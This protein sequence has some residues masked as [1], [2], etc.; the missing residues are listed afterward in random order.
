MTT[1]IALVFAAAL[2]SGCLFD[3]TYCWESDKSKCCSDGKLTDVETDIDCGGGICGGCAD[4]KACLLPTDCAS[5]VCTGFVCQAP[6]CSDLVKNGAETGKDC[7]GATCGDCPVGEGCGDGN[8]CESRSCAGNLCLA[9]TCEDDV[10][11][12]DETDTDCGGRDCPACGA[13]GKCD[14]DT[15]NCE[16]GLYCDGDSECA[17]RLSCGEIAECAQGCGSAG[18]I[19]SCSEG[20]TDS[21][22]VKFDALTNCT[23]QSCLQACATGNGCQVCVAQNCAAEYTA[24]QN[25]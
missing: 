24:C 14:N 4:T 3:P 19:S 8:D 22:T 12:D 13:N 7:G 20:G 10:Q 25:D 21:A 11:N 18:C 23:F 15:G 5:G 16:E 17:P 6:T 2:S 9:P 1:R